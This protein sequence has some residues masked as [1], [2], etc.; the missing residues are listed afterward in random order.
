MN[1]NLLDEYR[2]LDRKF[3]PPHPIQ[4]SIQAWRKEKRYDQ[5]S[6]GRGILFPI[7]AVGFAFMEVVSVVRCCCGRR[8][9]FHSSSANNRRA[10]RVDKVICG[11]WIV[12]AIGLAVTQIDPWRM[13]TIL[14]SSIRLLDILQ[15]TM[16][17]LFFERRL[18]SRNGDESVLIT[19]SVERTA[20]LSILNYLE[21]ILLFSII[22]AHGEFKREGGYVFLCEVQALYYSFTTQTTL[23]G[24]VTPVGWMT[25][26]SGVQ[27]FMGVLIVV[28]VLARIVN[29]LGR[30]RP[31][32]G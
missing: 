2:N 23:G 29:S 22:Y 13:P 14:L 12:E 27:V 6:R 28:L 15:A 31:S 11:C 17:T 24:D 3:F 32:K 21:V 1:V 10:K 7:L 19:A 20:F 16:N 18:R 8:R 9:D 30:L 25:F 4:W 5:Q 26:V